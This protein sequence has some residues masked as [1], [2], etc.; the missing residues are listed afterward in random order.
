MYLDFWETYTHIHDIPSA[1]YVICRYV[2]T[3]LSVLVTFFS[4]ESTIP[5]EAGSAPVA[6]HDSGHYV[7][8]DLSVSLTRQ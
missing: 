5:S 3:Y 2:C 6:V 8:L 1:M 7:F 4:F